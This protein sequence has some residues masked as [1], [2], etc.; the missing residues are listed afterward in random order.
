MLN[1]IV[2]FDR[3]IINIIIHFVPINNPHNN[4]K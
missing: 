4:I 3:D 2:V 1:L